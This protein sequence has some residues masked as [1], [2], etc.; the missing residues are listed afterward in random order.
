MR[1]RL[2]E[3][4][5][6]KPLYVLPTGIPLDRFAAGDGAG[7]RFRHGIPAR[8]P[9][10]LFVGRVAHEKNIGFLLEALRHARRRCPDLLLVIAGEGPAL[11]ALRQ[12]AAALGLESVQK[13]FNL[14]KK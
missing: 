7:F 10:A 1:L 12:Q 8:S 9:V 14:P 11:K 6:T 4:G 13:L 3:Y 2:V 5:V